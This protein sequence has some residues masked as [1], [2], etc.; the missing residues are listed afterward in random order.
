M[1]LSQAL[2]EL[3]GACD[4]YTPPV[5]LDKAYRSLDPEV[6]ARIL[7]TPLREVSNEDAGDLFHVMQ[8]DD[9]AFAYFLPRFVELAVSFETP[10]H[11]P[12]LPSIGEQVR[13]D[14][15]LAE[16][17]IGHA[18]EHVTN[19]LWEVLLTRQLH[20][21]IIEDIVQGSAWFEDS[22]QTRLDEWSATQ[23]FAGQA[24]L[25]AYVIYN[26][27]S[28][29]TRRRLRNDRDWRGRPQVEMEVGLWLRSKAIVERVC[30]L[31]RSTGAA[32]LV[33]ACSGLK[34]L[35]TAPAFR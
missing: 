24:N 15:L 9:E 4:S 6:E 29:R 20:S 35:H 7:K 30:E 25:A 16:P 31:A 2:A 33:E 22:L 1:D 5:T 14:R 21:E 23:H 28:V 3:Y 17:A 8:G 26:L 13:R 34:A 32:G 19:A 10:F 27:D 12:D 18:I 11:F